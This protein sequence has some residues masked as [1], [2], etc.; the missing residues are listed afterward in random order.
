MLVTS[1]LGKGIRSLLAV[2]ALSVMGLPFAIAQVPAQYPLLNTTGGGV[3]PNFMLTMD[4]SGSMA[5]KHMPETV[6]AGGTFATP[7][8]VNTNSVRWDPADGYMYGVNPFGTVRGDK[9]TTNYVL[10]AMRSP[11][12]N[13]MYYNPEILYQPWAV[14]TYPLPAAVTGVPAGR[15]A[16]SPPAAAFLDPANPTTGGVINLTAY[17]APGGSSTWC[18]FNVTA[19]P[20]AVLAG[21]FVVGVRYQITVSSTN[22][23]SIGSASNSVGTSFVAT[24]AGSGAGRAVPNRQCDSIANND[25]SVS[26]HDPGVYFRLNTQTY[27]A[28]V[29]QKGTTYTIKAVGTS[30]ATDFTKLG[31]SNNLIGTTFTATASNTGTGNGTAT[32]YSDLTIHTNYT[33]YSINAVAGTTFLKTG[34]RSDCAGSTC[35]R[36]EERQNFANWYTY[37]RNRNLLA[38]GAM[39]ESFANV[40]NTVR[41]G[42]GRINKGLGTVDTVSTRVIESAATGTAAP[43]RSYGGGGVRPFDQTRKTQLFN[44]LLDL[45][46][47]GGTPLP[48]AMIAVGEY[49]K[50]TDVQGPYT[51]NP[52]VTTNTVANNKSCRRSYNLMM[53]DGYWNGAVAVGNVDSLAIPTITG[54]GGASFSLPANTLP[55]SDGVPDTLADI[56]MKYWSEDLQPDVGGV[57]K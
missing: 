25:P 22:F 1:C 28:N 34:K 39:M 14:S 29:L 37:Y 44:W 38:R 15:M 42:F 33:A 21:A 27:A 35:T 4:D 3:P 24:A 20:A 17:V 6:F 18:N 10:R 32:G 8:P 9:N 13:T 46:A 30:P 7:N 2:S 56:A 19:P 31:A 12:T 36:T 48:A 26:S 41:L 5:F 11:D 52:S 49:Y 23:T 47:A 43:Y 40:G 57:P 53:T 45:P 54:P 51:D 55:Y 50:R 16:D